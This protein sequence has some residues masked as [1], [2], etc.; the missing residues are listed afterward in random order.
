MGF[1]DSAVTPAVPPDSLRAACEAGREALAGDFRAR[2]DALAALAG[3]TALADTT[4]ASLVS[5]L[6]PYSRSERSRYGLVAIG[7]YGRRALFPSSDLDVLLLCADARAAEAVSGPGAALVRALWDLGWRAS[8][9]SRLLD[10]CDRFEQDNPEFT[11]SL[12]D[13]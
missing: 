9:T 11:I 13:A 5:L 4:L 2:G 6:F 7:G 12:L 3:R 8:V 1:L 10:E